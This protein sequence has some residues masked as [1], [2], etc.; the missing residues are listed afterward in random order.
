[1][2]R[3][4]ARLD[5]ATVDVAVVGGGVLGA[6]VARAAARRGLAVALL[7]KRDFGCAASANNLRILHGG[8]RSLSRGHISDGRLSRA[9]LVEWLRVA[10]HL[11]DPLPVL[12]PTRS[13]ALPRV[14][15][16]FSNLVLGPGHAAAPPRARSVGRAEL[17]AIWP[18]G[19]SSPSLP[20]A[21]LEFEDGLAYSPER[22]VL[23][24]VKD[25]VAAGAIVVNHVEAVGARVRGDR[26]ERL[27]FR[28]APSGAEGSLAPGLVV[29]A[30]GGAVADVAERLGARLSPPALSFS[31][32]LLVGP[33][34]LERALGVGEA[35]RVFFV[36]WREATAIGTA[37]HPVG[38]RPALDE[39][40]ERFLAEANEAW[41]G[42]PIGSDEVRHVQT[43]W[44]LADSAPG[45][46]A[47]VSERS[48]LATARGTGPRNLVSAAA[49]KLTTAPAFARRVLDAGF[50]DAGLS[51]A[52]PPRA[53]PAPGAADHG[54]PGPDGW[55]SS[56]R[57]L[58][59]T[60]AD[61][62]PA[63]VVAHTIRMYGRESDRVLAPDAAGRH[64]RVV[65]GAPVVRAHL[66]YAVEHEM[67]VTEADLLERRSELGP[68]GLVDERAR[69][70]ARAALR[71]G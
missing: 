58:A 24:L 10:P 16:A 40:V 70:A 21:A 55:A 31:L 5:G 52:G 42:E 62:A 29:N 34:G 65:E 54:E 28:D 14:A 7:E 3:D 43:G 61:R 18:G 56:A 27:A 8:V 26:I 33:L 15:S 67:A 38:A 64:E 20:V 17:A 22:L 23:A 13:R 69:A 46:P 32:N 45:E 60:L 36:P 2:R 47:R 71:G 48:W 25:A 12:A 9:Q 57:A 30:A 50:R 66:A 51:G 4:P 35:R 59:A 49:H 1:M 68:R 53:D 44:V 6:A 63:D 39:A 19:P 41:P 37:H 11:V